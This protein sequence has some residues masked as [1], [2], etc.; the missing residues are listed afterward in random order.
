MQYDTVNFA[1][2]YD[3]SNKKKC[4]PLFTELEN[5]IRTVLAVDSLLSAKCY[6][7]AFFDLISAEY[8]PHP[9]ID[10]RDTLPLS[11]M[12]CNPRLVVAAFSVL[13]SYEHKCND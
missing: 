13:L 1:V 6:R 2:L 10:L 8:A 4:H 12:S 7:V 9:P 5:K 11:R 3:T